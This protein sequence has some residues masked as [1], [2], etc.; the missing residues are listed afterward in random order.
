MVTSIGYCKYTG[1]FSKMDDD[2]ISSVK[3][4]DIQVIM[5]SNVEFGILLW[6][7]IQY[8]ANIFYGSITDSIFA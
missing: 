4:V 1:K 5:T 3:S 6:K 7:L 2:M 8:V